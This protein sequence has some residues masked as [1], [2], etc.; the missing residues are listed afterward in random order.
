M[1]RIPTIFPVHC[2]VHISLFACSI[3]SVGILWRVQ[4]AANDSKY[5]E[6]YSPL[7][8]CLYLLKRQE[9]KSSR[10]FT[11]LNSA[12]FVKHRGF[13]RKAHQSNSYSILI[14]INQS[15][16]I[17]LYKYNNFFFIFLYYPF[18]PCTIDY[19]FSLTLPGKIKTITWGQ[20]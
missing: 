7:S 8:F 6:M 15:S 4:T 2:F 20:N 19:I 12:A 9:Q 1:F 17:L 10:S 16:I 11:E 14:C 3:L 5:F 18:L 13:M